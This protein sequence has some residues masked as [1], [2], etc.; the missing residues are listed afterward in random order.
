MDFIKHEQ[1]I[2]RYIKALIILVVIGVIICIGITVYEYK[3]YYEGKYSY[4]SSK[5]L[6]SPTT[7]MTENEKPYA[8]TFENEQYDVIYIPEE[9]TA[10]AKEL[11]QTNGEDKEYV[12][13]TCI[14][15]K[16]NKSMIFSLFSLGSFTYQ[17]ID[18]EAAE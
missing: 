10:K 3:Y 8:V 4:I 16:E 11:L 9:L 17:I 2:L 6:L 12:K 13:V 5:G 15:K 18:I 14:L 7:F 1:E